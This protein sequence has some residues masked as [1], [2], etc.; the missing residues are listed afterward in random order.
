MGA[1]T[2]PPL[3]TPPVSS[4]ETFED[5]ENEEDWGDLSPY[6]R[7][8]RRRAIAPQ[9]MVKSHYRSFCCVW[10]FCF[11]DPQCGVSAAKRED[12]GMKLL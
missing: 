2:L 10:A 5:E 9:A 11:K 6:E 3:P 1:Q 7:E 12:T 8:R 4:E